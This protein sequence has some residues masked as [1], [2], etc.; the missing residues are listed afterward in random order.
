[1]AVTGPNYECLYYDIGTNGRV[2]DGGVWE[3]A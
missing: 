1:M 2:N 3:S